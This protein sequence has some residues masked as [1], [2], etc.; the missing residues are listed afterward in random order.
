MYMYADGAGWTIAPIIFV[1]M[2]ILGSFFLLNLTL[3]VL[4]NH[5]DSKMAEVEA[6]RILRASQTIL[7]NKIIKIYR[8]RMKRRRRVA[9]IDATMKEAQQQGDGD[10]AL[11]RISAPVASGG[12][13]SRRSAAL[14]IASLSDGADWEEK[15]EENTAPKCA[16]DSPLITL[17]ARVGDGAKTALDKV[18]AYWNAELTEVWCQRC[19]AVEG[20]GAP[21][22]AFSIACAWPV[23]IVHAFVEHWAFQMFIICCILLSLWQVLHVEIEMRDVT[24]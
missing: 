18:A 17:S 2:I 1:L 5:F 9:D 21:E 22:T 24:D 7:V 15:E 20:K 14:F 16:G 13:K 19:A 3:A 4:G 8:R 6:D 11:A 10:P 12:A 23:K